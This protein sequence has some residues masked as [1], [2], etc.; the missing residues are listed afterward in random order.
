MKILSSARYKELKLGQK[1]H[2]DINFLLELSPEKAGVALHLLEKSK[3]QWRQDLFALSEMNFKTNGYFVEFGATD[4]VSLSNTFMLEKHFGW[5]GLLAE[6]ATCWASSLKANR[7]AQIEFDCVWKKTGDILTFNEVQKNAAYSTLEE[8]S[9]RDMHNRKRKKGKRYE[10][11]TVSLNDMLKRNSAPSE[12]D[13]LS[14]DT[15]GS[16][17]D[18]LNAVDFEK[19]RFSV[20]TCE[21]N[22]TASRQKIFDLLVSKGY[23]RKF[24]NVSRADD[25]YVLA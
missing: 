14:I 22:F 1:C 8:F 13:Y 24:E 7:T 20:I 12:I 21:H 6:P 19:Y 5:R 2:S 15:E 25:W 23:R 11:R 9:A 10:V 17:F 18:I 4:G 16:E 3:A